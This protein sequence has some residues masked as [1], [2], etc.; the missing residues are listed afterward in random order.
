[1]RTQYSGSSVVI[2]SLDMNSISIN[3]ADATPNTDDNKD[4]RKNWTIS[5]SNILCSLTIQYY[6]KE[7]GSNELISLPSVVVTV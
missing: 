4:K 5:I 7:L 6:Y 3:L 1:M 2:A